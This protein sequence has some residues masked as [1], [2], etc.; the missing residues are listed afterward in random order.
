MGGTAKRAQLLAV[1]EISRRALTQEMRENEV[2]HSPA[3]VKQYLQL[4]LAQLKHEVFA[5]LF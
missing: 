3:V 2:M 1:L 4:E 5:V